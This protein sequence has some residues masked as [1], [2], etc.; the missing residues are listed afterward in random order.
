MYKLEGEM[1][2]TIPQLIDHHHQ[3]RSII[4]SST[5]VILMNPVRAAFKPGDQYS[6]PHSDVRLDRSLGSGHFGEVYQGYLVSKKIPVAIKSCKPKDD[7]MNQKQKFVEEAEIMKTCT[8]AN[9]VKFIGICMEEDPH[10]ICKLLHVIYYVCY[11]RYTIIF[12]SRYTLYITYVTVVY[13]HTKWE[14]CV[15]PFSV[16]IVDFIL[17]PWMVSVAV[18]L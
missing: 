12:V 8:H 18:T 13:Y 15:L 5:G 7:V 17:L 9:L 4:Q 10:Y 16:L 11:L 2:P 6:F 14:V 3:N 1:F